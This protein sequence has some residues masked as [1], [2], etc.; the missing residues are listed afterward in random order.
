MFA[1]FFPSHLLYLCPYFFS[2]SCSSRNSEPG[3]QSRLFSLPHAT[4]L[5]S[6]FHHEG[7]FGL[8][9]SLLDPKM[10]GSMSSV[11]SN[12]V[13]STTDDTYQVHVWGQHCDP[14]RWL[15]GPS[16]AL[17]LVHGGSAVGVRPQD[18]AIPRQWHSHETSL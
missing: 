14:H 16:S 15:A 1:C 17:K 13:T 18:D 3:T 11:A 4:V 9:S 2:S 10:S 12:A 6:H 7:H 8:F 5:T